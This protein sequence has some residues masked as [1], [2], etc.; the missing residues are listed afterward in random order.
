M[1]EIKIIKKTV[2][3]AACWFSVKMPAVDS[4]DADAVI[5]VEL[6]RAYPYIWVNSDYSSNVF[7]LA[8]TYEDVKRSAVIDPETDTLTGFNLNADGILSCNGYAARCIAAGA[9]KTFYVIPGNISSPMERVVDPRGL[10]VS[11][12]DMPV[13]PFVHTTSSW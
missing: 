7:G 10:V 8:L 3:P 2:A 5:K 13:C 12:Q 4:E 6:D 11:A 1:D 9:R